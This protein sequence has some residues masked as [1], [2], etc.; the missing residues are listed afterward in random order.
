MAVTIIKEPTQL[1]P[2]Y[3]DSFLQFRDS[4]NNSTYADISITGIL[5]QSIRIYANSNNVF[6]LN[7]KDFIK[8]SFSDTGFEDKALVP[9][10]EDIQVL[11]DRIVNQRIVISLEDANDSETFTYS[12]FRDVNQVIETNN[13]SLNSLLF[14]NTGENNNYKITYFEGF[15]FFIEFKFLNVEDEVTLINNRTGVSYTQSLQFDE[16]DADDDSFNS[17]ISDRFLTPSDYGTCRVHLDKITSNVTTD[18][19]FP[20]LENTVNDISYLINGE[21]KGNIE[22]TARPAKRG[23]YLKW[24][25]SKG[26]YSHFKFSEFSRKRFRGRHT[27][28]L[29]RNEIFNVNDGL[30]TGIINQGQSGEMDLR[31]RDNITTDELLH[32]QDILISP[33]VQMY[34]SNDPF[35]IGGYVDVVLEGRLPMNTKQ[36]RHDITLNIDLPNLNTITY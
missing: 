18:S 28:F 7:L 25:N 32:I 9:L 36:P 10:D 6:T 19:N 16:D 30:K 31:I 11:T 20:I 8:V 35:T 5:E 29:T 21:L 14:P 2:A 1:Y 22:L 27:E 17:L 34:L 15:P 23:I 3:N 33:S 26:G 24:Y 12:F 13:E 4:N